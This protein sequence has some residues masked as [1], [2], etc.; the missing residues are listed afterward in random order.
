[1]N[2]KWIEFC[3]LL[4]ISIR[5]A[6]FNFLSTD[7]ICNYMLHVKDMLCNVYKCHSLNRD[8][9][10]SNR[11]LFAYGPSDNHP[12]VPLLVGLLVVRYKSFLNT[13]GY[14]LISLR[15]KLTLETEVKKKEPGSV[16]IK[17]SLSKKRPKY[18]LLS[19]SHV[20]ACP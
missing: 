11:P 14:F 19:S 13:N 5:K 18:L 3:Y 20:H 8:S 15:D 17:A 6:F 10:I 12:L 9:L 2:L 7:M 4:P 16:V 1:M